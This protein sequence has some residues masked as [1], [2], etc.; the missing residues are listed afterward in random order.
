MY[1]KN[2]VKYFIKDENNNKLFLN[3][4]SNEILNKFN[5][6]KKIINEVNDKT[7]SKIDSKGAYKH[8][9]DRIV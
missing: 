5:S 1:Q 8:E 2:Q 9:R 7:P 6:V 3:E 4:D